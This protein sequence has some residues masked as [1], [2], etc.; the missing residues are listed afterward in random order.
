VSADEGWPVGGVGGEVVGK[1]VLYSV[2]QF[3]VSLLL[4]LISISPKQFLSKDQVL[5]H[6]NV[7]SYG[8]PQ[9]ASNR[10]VGR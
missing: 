2:V 7:F 10:E 1:G 3:V 4:S 9:E 6:S 5:M 8:P